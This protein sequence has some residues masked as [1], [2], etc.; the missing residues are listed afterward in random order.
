LRTQSD[1]PKPWGAIESQ[2]TQTVT[3][4]HQL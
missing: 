3:I 4:N 1:T 2:Y